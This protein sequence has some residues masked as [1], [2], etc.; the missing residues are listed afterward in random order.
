MAIGPALLFCPADRPDRYA[1]AAI[2]ADSVILDL[3]DAVAPGAKASARLSLIE[4]RLDP[5][6][7][8]VRVNPGITGQLEADIAAL[9]RTSYRTVML[10]KAETEADLALLAGFDVIAI[11][12]SPLGV[13]NAG[14]LARHPL[15]VAVT[16]VPKISW[17]QSGAGR[18]GIQ[19]EATGSSRSTPDP[20]CSSL[21]QVKV[22]RRSTQCT[23]TSPTRT[24]YETRHRMRRRPDSPGL[25]A[26]TLAR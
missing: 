21:R 2:A 20:A 4:L 3:E 6:H 22:S 18:A 13:Q 17:R 8:I 14:L 1:K 7:T 25:C 9:R 24:V 26:S 16:W 10:A 12:E 11:C 5:R 23:S 15:V 19:M